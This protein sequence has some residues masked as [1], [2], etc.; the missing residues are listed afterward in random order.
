[1]TRPDLIEYLKHHIE[2]CSM[3]AENVA[4]SLSDITAKLDATERHSVVWVG[5]TSEFDS[6]ELRLGY[7]H[8]I[9]NMH[10]GKGSTS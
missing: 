2:L 8:D 9:L 1:M 5:L 6:L 10:V 7:L 3:E 4:C